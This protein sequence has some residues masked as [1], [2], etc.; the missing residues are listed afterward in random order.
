MRYGAA[1]ALCA[2]FPRELNHRMCVYMCIRSPPTVFQ[3]NDIIY[4][5]LLFTIARI[6]YNFLLEKKNV[7]TKII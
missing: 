7:R 3:N 4:Y 6:Y 2:K 1:L 5:V